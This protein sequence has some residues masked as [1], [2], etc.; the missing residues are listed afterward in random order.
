MY[1]SRN[2]LMAGTVALM[3]AVALA[4]CSD[5]A[6]SPLAP[7]SLSPSLKRASSPSA[8]ATQTTSTL[9]DFAAILIPG[10]AGPV[11]LGATETISIDGHGH[12]DASSGDALH[13]LSVKGGNLSM[14]ASE[15]GLGLCRF[16]ATTCSFPDD[17]DEVGDRGPGTLLLNF[18]GVEPAGSTVREI[19]LGSL[20]T[21]EGYRVSIS[22]DGGATFGTA[23]E[24]FPNNANE[25]ATVAINEPAA[26]LV[27]KLEKTAATGN[28]DN[29]YTVRTVTTEFTN[30]QLE[31]RLTG[32]GV[33]AAGSNGETVTM[34]MTLHCDI[35]L[36]NNLEVNWQGHKWH[37]TKPIT[38]ASCSNQQNDAP[39]P[40][41][42]IDT[43]VGTAYGTLD[44][45]KDSYIEFNFQD[46]GEPGTNDKVELTIYEPGS[47]TV[48]LNVPMQNSSVGNLQMHYDQPHGSHP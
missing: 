22:T 30:T 9:W 7:S 10:Q 4:G 28:G 18:N 34:G 26:N 13:H 8:T 36:S 12:I 33:K 45:V 37:L 24:A 35:L 16:S 11:D 42:P 31:G 41:S 1:E 43:F 23:M 15:R 39:P 38:S 19:T 32:G 25:L 47:S 48:A 17:G 6:T 46:H 40:A 14:D 5:Q 29:D 27:I 20:Q 21:D 44:G 3:I 2:R